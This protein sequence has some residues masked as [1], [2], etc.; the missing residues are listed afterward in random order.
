MDRWSVERAN[1]WWDAQPWICGFNFLPSTAVNFLEMWHADTFDQATIA[2][3]LG[4]AAD[5][6]FNAIRL[7]LHFLVWKHDREGLLDRLDWVLAMAS[8][9]GM[10]TVLCF[11]DDCGFGGF[12]PRYGA[13]PDPV[14]GVHNSRAVASPGRA[15]LLDEALSD[16]LETYLREIVARH[17]SDER[18]LVWDLYNE[19]GNRMVFGRE[20]AET[21]KPDIT[22]ASLHL[23]QKA[24]A[25]A[26]EESP[27]QPLTVG[28][29]STP[30][31]GS[32]GEPYQTDIDQTAIALSDVIS[33]HAYW[34][35]ARVLGFIDL[36]ARENRPMLCTEW[37]ARTVGSK[38]E[39]QLAL[40]R[41]RKVGCFQW[42]FVN[43]R[44]QTHLPWP[45]ELLAA[46]GGVVAEHEWFHDLLCADGKPYDPKEIAVV[47]SLAGA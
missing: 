26:R 15:A 5:I 9:L 4:W 43:G 21:Y 12:E 7:N 40:F 37:M 27:S 16:E 11:F 1:A 41:A 35:A 10:R 25:W 3:E 47:R 8:G 23:M 46:H 29:W 34:N 14:P 44:T 32:D 24:F 42:G 20:G 30:K 31:P 45:S 13:Q 6:G 38:I 22:A 17:A 19:P 2:R 18:V 33:F 39:D 28:A 36:L